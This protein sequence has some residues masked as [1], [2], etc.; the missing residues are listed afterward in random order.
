GFLEVIT[1]AIDGDIYNLMFFA[2]ID[3]QALMGTFNCMEKDIETW[4]PVARAMME[5][6]QF[7]ANGVE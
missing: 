2:S 1:P 6:L 5:T 3:G 7:T 4:Q